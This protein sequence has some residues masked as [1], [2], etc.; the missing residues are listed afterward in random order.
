MQKHS[1]IIYEY[2]EKYF[3][4]QRSKQDKRQDES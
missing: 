2:N 1:S 4:I 3:I